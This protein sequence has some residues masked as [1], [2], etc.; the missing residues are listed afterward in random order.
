[1]DGIIH[2]SLKFEGHMGVS[3]TR[4]TRTSNLKYIVIIRF[5]NYQNLAKWE[6]TREYRENGLR[7]AK[8]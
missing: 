2:E 3:R 4:T 1:M 6:K 7:K 8:M 5:D